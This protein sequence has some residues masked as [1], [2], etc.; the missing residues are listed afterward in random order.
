[1]PLPLDPFFCSFGSGVS[2]GITSV[3]PVGT[4][5][6]GEG[7]ETLLHRRSVYKKDARGKYE[8]LLPRS[9]LSPSFVVLSLT[10][11]FSHLSATRLL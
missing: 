1:M 5:Y 9:L 10:F 3:R 8:R 6:I 11:L 2:L 7:L 4:A